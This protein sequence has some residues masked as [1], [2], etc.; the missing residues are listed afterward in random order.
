MRTGKAKVTT[1]G[2]SPGNP[3]AAQLPRQPQETIDFPNLAQIMALHRE[4]TF[5]L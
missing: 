4:L 1:D 3:K 5:E 2:N